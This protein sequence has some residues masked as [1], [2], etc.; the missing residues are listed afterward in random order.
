META[1]L[2]LLAPLTDSRR[3]HTVEVGRKVQAVAHH[4]PD[5]LRTDTVVSAYL[6]DV[7]Y[8][9]PTTGFH[10]I[11]GANLLAAHGYSEIVCHLVAFHSASTVEAQIR[12]FD[13]V[14]FRR[15]TLLDVPGLDVANDFV[16]WA[17]MTTGPDG[18][19]L[20]IDQRLSDIRDRYED[21]SIVRT[22][23]DRSEP[24]LRGAVQRVEGSM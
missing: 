6:H 3:A 18:E 4:I 21:G 23:I 10:P 13:D 1:L 15:F 22:A 8:G 20:T 16:W 5:H 2:E 17:D 19:T 11:D 12:G 9:Y 7:G 24:L 14:I